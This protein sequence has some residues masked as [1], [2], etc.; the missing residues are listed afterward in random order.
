MRECVLNE[1]KGDGLSQFSLLK[2]AA[3]KK[4]ILVSFLAWVQAGSHAI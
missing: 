3:D 2:H 4:Q 1:Q